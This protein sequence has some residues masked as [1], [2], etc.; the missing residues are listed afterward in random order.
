MSGDR[1]VLIGL[2]HPRSAW[3][4]ELSRWSNSASI[5]VEFLKCISAEEVRARL[6]S[7]RAHSALIV[8]AS[9]GSF[10]RDLVGTATASGTPVIAVGDRRG[11]RADLADLGVAATLGEGF[12]RDELLEVLRAHCRRITRGDLLP[13]SLAEAEVPIWKGRLVAV[14]GPG[15][16]GASSAAIALAQGAAGDPRYG[17]RV[18]LA[19]LALRADQA[20]LHDAGELGPGLQELV[21]AHRLARPASDDVR[22]ATFDVPRRGYRLLLGLRQPSAWAVLRPRAVD[23]AL[24]GMRRSFQLVVAD[25]DGDTDGEAE[26][27]SVD[28]EER[29]HLARL[30]ATSADA[31]FAVGAP[32]LKGTHS[33]AG[34][35]CRLVALGV[36]A[37][38]VV[39]VVNRGPRSPRA[40]AELAQALAG[41]VGASVALAS[42]VMLPERSL[43]TALRDG[44]PVNA[45]LVR[46]LVGALAAVLDRHAD[47][48]PPGATLEQVTPGELGHWGAEDVE[49]P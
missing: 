5:A 9:L 48:A 1:Y 44:S 14:C 11:A 36:G 4:K 19:D 42:P 6:S 7:G 35:L 23:A 18:L 41:L 10:D 8:D 45:A 43:E 24:E 12:G 21:E 47:A 20:M 16:T 29:N 39:P 30:V 13:P 37:S 32:G 40:K 2:A 22:R 46:P 15:G 33:L 25:I 31:V 27:G 26:T 34:L 3:F 38:R 17:G 28:I 49:A